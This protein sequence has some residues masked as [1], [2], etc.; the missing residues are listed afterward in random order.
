M[1]ECHGKPL[2]WAGRQNRA[3]GGGFTCAV[4]KRANQ[5][6]VRARSA[7]A[8]VCRYCRDPELETETMCARC[9]AGHRDAA[10]KHE[11]QPRRQLA[12]YLSN[13]QIR[14]RQSAAKVYEGSP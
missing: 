9:A 3:G 4:R 14:V 13:T 6:A 1:C 5:R 8:G 11:Q 7:E 12:K 2:Y 10:W